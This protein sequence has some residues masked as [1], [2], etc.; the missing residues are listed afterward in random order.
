[1][2]TEVTMEWLERRWDMR[3]GYVDLAPDP[4]TDREKQREKF[5]ISQYNTQEE[6]INDVLTF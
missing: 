5:D 3:K 4:K 2:T 1:M 6:Y